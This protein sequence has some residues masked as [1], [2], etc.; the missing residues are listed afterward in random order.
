MCSNTLDIEAA[1]T[2]LRGDEN[3]NA[4]SINSLYMLSGMLGLYS[5]DRTLS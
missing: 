3:T 4:C 5:S 2:P 1:N